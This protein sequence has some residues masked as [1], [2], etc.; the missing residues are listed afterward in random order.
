MIS[1]I[2]V[3]M[4]TPIQHKK[5]FPTMI[6]DSMQHLWLQNI[7]SDSRIIL[8]HDLI[9]FFNKSLTFFPCLFVIFLIV[10]QAQV[11]YSHHQHMRY[12]ILLLPQL[13]RLLVVHIEH[14]LIICLQ[15]NLIVTE[16]ER[17]YD[18]LM[19]YEFHF[20]QFLLQQDLIFFDLKREILL[21][22][23]AQIG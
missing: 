6:Q 20:V 12:H 22:I 23:M 4:I 13:E 19:L 15:V 21:G 7:I 10:S 9:R 3:R 2:S 16:A 8:L 5:M 1:T 18:D 14:I 11:S 17:Q